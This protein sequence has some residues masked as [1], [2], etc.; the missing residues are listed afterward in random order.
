[1]EKLKTTGI[2]YL[3]ATPIGNLGDIS[4]RAIDTIKN[5]DI[6][7][8]EDTRHT[9]I[10][11]KKLGL[12]PRLESY[13]EHNKTA[14]GPLLIDQIKNGLNIALVSDA[15]MP[16]ISDPG[17]ELVKLCVQENISVVV[18]PGPCAAVSA[19]SGCDFDTSRFVFEGFVPVKGIQRKIRIEEIADEKR[20]VVIYEAPHRIQKTLK[21]LSESGMGQR[22][23]TIARELT[24]LYEEFIRS[25]VDSA[26]EYFSVKEPRGEFVIVI[27][28]KNEFLKRVSTIDNGKAQDNIDEKIEEFI[29]RQIKDGLS[30][31]DIAKMAAI[32][33]SIQKKEIYKLV[34]S[35]K[36]KSTFDK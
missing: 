28:G 3:V 21:D 1:M 34:V 20:T 16:C 7:A 12:S 18:I 8:A 27:E 30:V 2:L 11:M 5:A 32:K 17:S 29:I 10:L 14:K 25:N 23:V 6:I 35:V 36:D 31:N 26:I 19:I 33:F 22:R 9:G 24:K 13:H 4:S 15:G